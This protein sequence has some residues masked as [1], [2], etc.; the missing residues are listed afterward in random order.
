VCSRIVED[1]WT[2]C[3][4]GRPE[5]SSID[6]GHVSRTVSGRRIA[7]SAC[8]ERRPGVRSSAGSEGRLNVVGLSPVPFS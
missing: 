8:V 3:R 2:V 4:F 5:G 7:G 6:G 1:V